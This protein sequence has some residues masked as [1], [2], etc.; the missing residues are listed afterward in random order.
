MGRA[1]ICNKSIYSFFILPF[2]LAPTLRWPQYTFWQWHSLFLLLSWENRKKKNCPTFT[3]NR[4]LNWSKKLMEQWLPPNP[5]GQFRGS[6][7]FSLCPRRMPTLAAG[8]A[9]EIPS[10]ISSDFPLFW[11]M[12]KNAACLYL[13]YSFTNSQPCY[14]PWN[15]LGSITWGFLLTAWDLCFK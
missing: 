10:H 14:Q 9:K 13:N 11:Q 7:K 3:F 8:K 2:L 12:F 4:V 1:I 6:Q 5:P 15:P